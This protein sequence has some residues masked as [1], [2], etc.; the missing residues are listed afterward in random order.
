MRRLAD[1]SRA[2]LVMPTLAEVEPECVDVTVGGAEQVVLLDQSRRTV[3]EGVSE[4]IAHGRRHAR[5]DRGAIFVMPA[6][7]EVEPQRVDVTVRCPKQVVLL[8]DSG[9]A[10]DERVAERVAYRRGYAGN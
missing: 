3:D 8:D 5:H 10:V 7:A 9:R 6:L 1:N 4:R 2:V